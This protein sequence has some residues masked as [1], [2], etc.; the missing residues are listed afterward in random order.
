[1]HFGL[2]DGQ[3]GNGANMKI[4]VNMLMGSMLASYAEALAL[5][6]AAGLDAEDF[7]EVVNTGALAAPIFAIKAGCPIQTIRPL[8]LT[9]DLCQ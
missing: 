7:V 6:E 3:V 1:M 2:R 4:A 8:Q 9:C 5:A